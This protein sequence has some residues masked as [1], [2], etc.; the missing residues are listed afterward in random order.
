VGRSIS[1]KEVGSEGWGVDAIE[2]EG[3]VSREAKKPKNGEEKEK[4]YRA[5]VIAR[6]NYPIGKNGG[7]LDLNNKALPEKKK[8]GSRGGCIPCCRDLTPIRRHKTGMFIVKCVI[9]VRPDE[10]TKTC[11]QSFEGKNNPK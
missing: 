4:I 2:Y 6:G 1:S 7:E 3:N 9:S 5:R 8:G 10:R 11:K